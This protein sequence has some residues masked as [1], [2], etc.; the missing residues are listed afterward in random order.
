VIHI[1][2]AIKLQEDITI[3]N[4]IIL[5]DIEVKY[6]KWTTFSKELSRIE[7]VRKMSHK[8]LENLIKVSQIKVQKWNQYSRSPVFNLMLYFYFK[9]VVLKNS[10]LG[11]IEENIRNLGRKIKEEEITRPTFFEKYLFHKNACTIQSSL[12]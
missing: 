6:K 7:E 9:R 11:D 1:C 3:L 2:L 10:D 4:E 5:D 12:H 8:E